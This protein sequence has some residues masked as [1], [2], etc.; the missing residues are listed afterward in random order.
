MDRVDLHVPGANL[1]EGG[2]VWSAS[3]NAPVSP[4]P[5]GLANVV[6]NIGTDAREVEPSGVD[7]H[8]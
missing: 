4:E 1:E 7:T 6:V 2:G 3:A 8:E 5:L